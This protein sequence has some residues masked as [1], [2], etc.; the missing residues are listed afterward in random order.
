M[1]DQSQHGGNDGG[2]EVIDCSP[3]EAMGGEEIGSR[4]RARR[5]LFFKILKSQS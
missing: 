2:D 3:E 5:M 1:W 4:E